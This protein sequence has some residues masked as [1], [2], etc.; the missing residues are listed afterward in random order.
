MLVEIRRDYYKGGGG[1]QNVKTRKGM[2]LK[3]NTAS[4]LHLIF[5]NFLTIFEFFK[6]LE[7][8]ELSS[9]ISS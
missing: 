7:S 6:L 4:I 2:Q 8:C 5:H 1:G 3:I 9:G